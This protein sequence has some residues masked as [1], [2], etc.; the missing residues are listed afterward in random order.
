MTQT[1][2][3]HL[4][5][6]VMVVCS[7]LVAAADMRASCPSR[8]YVA[9]AGRNTWSGLIAAPNS[10]RT[11][12]PLA[13]LEDA[14][15]RIREF[16]E[17]GCA[18]TM[19]VIIRA[20]LYRLKEPFMLSPADSGSP[21]HPVIY[22]AYPGEQPIVSGGTPIT[23]WMKDD[24]GTWSAHETA[25]VTQL[26]INGTRAQRARVPY[27]GYFR[28]EGKSSTGEHYELHYKG[29]DIKP[30]WAGS[31]AEVVI[32]LAW[33]ETRRPIL[34]VDPVR[35]IAT[36]AGPARS[37]T[38]EENAR[39][40]I[41]NVPVEP[42]GSG[43]WREDARTQTVFYMPRKD[44]EGKE[45]EFTAPEFSQL[46]FMIGDRKAGATVHDIEIRGLSFEEAAWNLPDG[47]FADSQAAHAADSAIQVQDAERIRFV[48][49]RFRAMG[50]Y[51]VHIRHGSSSIAVVHS[52]FYDLGG[53]AVRVGEEAIPKED[54]E[55]VSSNNISD[56]DIHAIGLVY[57]SAVAIW[58]GQ[59]NNN[60]I[61]HN[62]IYDLPYGAISVGWTWG[63]G[64]SAADHNIIQSNWIHDIGT[65]LSDLGGVY[66]LGVQ[67]GTIVSKNLIYNAA[68][69]TYGGWGIYLDEGTS[70]VVVEN[71]VVY[72]AQSAGFH[73]H[74]GRNNLVRNNIFAFGHDYQIMRTR[75]E[76]TRSFTFEHNIVIYDQGSLLGYNWSGGGYRM[77][78][79]IYWDM[80]RRTPNFGADTWD[81]W[82]NK[83][84]D[85]HSVIADPQFVNTSNRNFHFRP[86]SPAIKMGIHLID[87][88]AV[89]PRANENEK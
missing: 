10:S 86:D 79:N 41:E 65:V 22:E 80:R 66:L 50:G 28:A 49:C 23:S 72:D 12:G 55:R 62:H 54:T 35:H 77:D 34:S 9:T 68:C 32:L 84:Y 3:K 18:G 47:G 71:N 53:G 44:D 58:V 82:R 1:I 6:K 42:L 37:S 29:D 4:Y 11:D 16:R 7:L 45:L 70:N 81:S 73:Q 67:P 8:F 2:G 40:W 48:N 87:L 61:S 21:T 83:G 20:G 85:V 74:Y 27:N 69:F 76:P 75:P 46:V 64:P 38:H 31:G 57:P 24:R 89:G 56:N 26:F 52:R 59:S 63:Y 39:F 5:W 88:A 36:L 78:W 25:S 19:H 33:A 14:R 17:R 13:S 60:S 51:A 30:E 15:G 43:E